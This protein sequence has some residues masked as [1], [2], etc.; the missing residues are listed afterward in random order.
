M[1]T[2]RSDI[3]SHLWHSRG[4]ESDSLSRWTL[5]AQGWWFYRELRTDILRE[6]LKMFKFSKHLFGNEKNVFN[7]NPKHP[8]ME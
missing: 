6:P 3:V 5:D 7:L 4:D 8:G 2:L 1:A